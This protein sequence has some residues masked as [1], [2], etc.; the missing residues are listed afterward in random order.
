[1]EV[2]RKKQGT[3]RLIAVLPQSVDAGRKYMADLGIAVDEVRQAP[4]SSLGVRGTP[5]L[6]LV[7]KD[8]VV[9]ISWVGRLK[10]EKELE[11]IAG[12]NSRRISHVK[13]EL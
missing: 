12:Y 7:N 4:P 10:P 8:G 6:I 1:M 11:V 5:T 3:T 13:T 2:I 9:T